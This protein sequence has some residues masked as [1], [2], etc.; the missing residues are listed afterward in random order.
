MSAMR[1]AVRWAWVIAAIGVGALSLAA[2]IGIVVLRP[3]PALA[4][5]LAQRQADSTRGAY[6]A[7]LGDCAFC[8]TKGGGQPFAGGLKLSTPIGAVYSSNITPDLA[9]GIGRYSLEDFIRV[10]RF[11]VR[12]DG[13]RLY[14]AMPYTA[15][16]RATDQDLQDLLAYLQSGVPPVHE[17]SRTSDIPWPLNFRWPLALWNSAF[18]DPSAFETDASRDDQWNRGA[19]L[20]EGLAHCG[21]CHT[22]RGLFFQEKDLRGRTNLYLSGTRLD[23]T[24][25]INL[26]GNEGDGLGRWSPEA[27]TV[28]LK[29]GRNERSAVTGSM[30]DV[31][32]HSTQYMSEQDVAAIAVY[33][34]SLSPAPGER[35]RFA[36]S[37]ATILTIMAGT[38]QSPGGRIYLD[39][40][41]AC[42]RLA[43][44]GENL[45]FPALAG[46]PTVLNSDPSS[47]IAVILNG[48]RAPPTDAAPT[49]LTMPGFAWRYDDIDIA[50]L[51]TFLRASWG[52]DAAP[53]S[54][55]QVSRR[56]QELRLS[57][58]DR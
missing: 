5:A 42:H 40:C 33:L 58:A 55:A 15:Y 14:P 25:P 18:H 21:T 48:A 28:L 38:E 47:L 53:V 31:V 50:A 52:N 13:N 46:N 36:A 22:P 37:D 30:A 20:V 57:R 6:I 9:T 7:V 2:V 23:G 35:A 3:D 27:I 34:K 44:G 45:T 8:H 41:A 12:P 16:A 51:A 24:S 19:Y 49:G 32:R 54:A 17:V 4:P 11:G 39:S 29:S 26:R 1:R 43:G 10:M 56:R